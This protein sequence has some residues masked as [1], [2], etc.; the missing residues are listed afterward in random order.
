MIRKT[1][2]N[3]RTLFWKKM[4]KFI[5]QKDQLSKEK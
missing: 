4:K 2:Y 1:S 5:K 3:T